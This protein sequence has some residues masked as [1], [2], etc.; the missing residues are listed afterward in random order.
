MTSFLSKSSF[1]SGQQCEKLLWFLGHN[2]EPS[3]DLDDAAK[4]RL[5]V[6]EQ[7]GNMAKKLFPNGTEI[8]FNFKDINLMIKQTAEAID[9]KKPVYEA[10]FLSE[11]II[12]R[13]DLMVN[14]E[15]GWNMY[16]VK[17][18]SSVKDYHYQDAAF[19]WY[20]LSL[21]PNL[22]MNK[23]YVVTINNKFS[24]D[25]DGDIKDLFNLSDVTEFVKSQVID[26]SHET[27][28]FKEIMKQNDVP[29]I[30]IGTHCSSP[31]ACQYKNDCWGSH[32]DDSI[33]N[34]YRMKSKD[35]FDLYNSG[36]KTFDQLP[37]DYRLTEIQKKQVLSMSKSEPIIDHAKIDDFISQ[38][39][40][41][42]SYL[43]F[44]TF[45]EAIPSYK[46]QKPYSQMPFQ[47]SLHVQNQP[48]GD[49]AHYEF[50]ADA[51]SDPR[52][53]IANKLLQWIPTEGTIIA[54]NQSFEMN[55]IKI[56]AD[57]DTNNSVSLLKLNERFLDLIIPFRKGYYYHPLFNGSFSIKNVLPALCPDDSSLRYDKLNITNGGDASLIYKNFNEVNPDNQ[58]KVLSDLYAYCRLDTLAM[59]RILEHLISIKK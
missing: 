20:A 57:A 58:E 30:E 4:D 26:I 41:P 50:I 35:K 31:H 25:Q 59:V 22:K 7:V 16:E 49:I 29:N 39:T 28:S 46:K 36:I 45:Q 21:I 17:S 55:C 33:L 11:D 14:G 2:Y 15:K 27:N 5:K 6:G 19:Q 8:D 12:V 54:Y 56:L 52:T 51:G 9:S 42:I 23:A 43:D 13:V 37:E 47:F 3:Q 1:I 10:T 24:N 32:E 18:S 44:E 34:L 38:I 53:S 48:L 40:Y